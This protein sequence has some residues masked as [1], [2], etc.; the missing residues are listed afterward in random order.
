MT[1]IIKTTQSRD[2]NGRFSPSRGDSKTVLF[3][4]IPTNVKEAIQQGAL[5]T[6]KTL[7][8]YLADLVQANQSPI[9]TAI[10]GP[11]PEDVPVTDAVVAPDKPAAV[12]A[13]ISF[14]ERPGA[15]Q[16]FY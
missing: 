3:L 10:P 6:G 7:S 4:R 9:S 12:K 2:G 16:R 14:V 13:K 11:K 15:R 8:A 1:H 5:A